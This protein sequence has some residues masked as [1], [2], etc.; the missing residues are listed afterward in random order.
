MRWI[1]GIRLRCKALAKRRQLDRDLEEEIRFH[2]TMRQQKYEAAGWAAGDASAAARRRFGNTTSPQ[3]ECREMWTFPSLE[4]F[5]QDLR[6]G[7]RQLR[8]S[9][10]FTVVAVLAL[11]LG[12]GANTAIFSLMNAVMLRT[13][14]V[15]QPDRLVLFGNA[16]AAGSTDDFPNGRWNL[17]SFPMYQE[18]AAKNH[19]FSGV[20]AVL[21]LPFHL[22]GTVGSRSEEH[23]SELQS[24]VHLVCRLLLEKKK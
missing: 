7:M 22:H 15:R 5:G 19:V 23:T 11:A 4:S 10:G 21:S 14:P 3:E 9:P 12:I 1:T 20:T 6:Y 8:R 16:R 17:F 13:L 2:L 18:I 24:P